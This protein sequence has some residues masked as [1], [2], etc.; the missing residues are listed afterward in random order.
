MTLLLV[1][2]PTISLWMPITM[3]E[4]SGGEKAE[5]TFVL[6]A[7]AKQSAEIMPSKA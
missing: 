7:V 4:A 2:V 5:W 3:K 6:T 1:A